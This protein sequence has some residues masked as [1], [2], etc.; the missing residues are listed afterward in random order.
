MEI[1]NEA[2][3]RE[4]ANHRALM[5]TQRQHKIQY[6]AIIIIMVAIFII[7][8][9]LGSLR[10][11]R[12]VIEFLGF[13]SFIFL[14]EFIVLIAD[15]VIED[16]THGE[17]WKVLGIKIILIGFLMPLHHLVERR[18]ISYLLNKKLIHF[19]SGSIRRFLN[20]MF[21]PHHHPG[22]S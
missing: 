22:P 14:F 9:V 1:D 3:Q 4:E 13:I 8:I 10:V 6:T 15:H 5:E 19:T 12:W 11:P 7:L 21:R 16:I 20:E 2:K 18:M 17:P